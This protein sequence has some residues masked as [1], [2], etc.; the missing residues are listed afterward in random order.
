MENA[1]FSGDYGGST[2]KYEISGTYLLGGP[3]QYFTLP[4]RGKC[5][6]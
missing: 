2:L 1:F 3:P 4:R 5:V 6:V